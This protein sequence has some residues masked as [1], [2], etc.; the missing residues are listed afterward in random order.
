MA[1]VGPLT[2]KSMRSEASVTAKQK[3][4]IAKSRK[5]E[6]DVL[7]TVAKPISGGSERGQLY[8]QQGDRI[9]WVLGHR[10]FSRDAAVVGSALATCLVS[11]GVVV[12]PWLPGD[13]RC[14]YR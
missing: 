7:M 9:S 3:V 10:A 4:Q 14:L 5:C 1:S 13:V 11:D 6:T 12:W 8:Q 2:H